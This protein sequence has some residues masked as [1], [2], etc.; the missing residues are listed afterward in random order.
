MLF[1]HI[2]RTIQRASHEPLSAMLIWGSTLCLLGCQSYTQSTATMRKSLARGHA[3]HALTALDQ[4][5]DDDCLD[6]DITSLLLLERGVTRQMVGDYKGAST[7]FQAAD[8]RLEVLDYTNTSVQDI[9]TYLF[10]GDSAPYRPPPFEKILVNLFNLS[11]YLAMGQWGGAKV[12]ARRFAVNESFFIDQG[13]EAI[14]YLST[15]RRQAHLM[16]AF[17][18]K[19]AGDLTLSLKHLEASGYTDLIESLTAQ[20]DEEGPGGSRADRP[21]IDVL[22]ITSSG[23]VPY[24]R[25]VRL[26]IGAALLYIDGYGM[27]A[28]QRRRLSILQA[29]GLVKW[30][31]FPKLVQGKAPREGRLTLDQEPVSPI[32]L[33]PLDDLAE[34]AF[35]TAR[36]KMMIGALTRLLT[37]A[38]T[39]ALTEQVTRKK[40][41]GGLGL[42]LSL[43]TEGAMSATD[44][45]DTRSWTALPAEQTLYWLRLPPGTH[46]FDWR[47]GRRRFRRVITLSADQQA[48]AI[49]FPLFKPRRRE[50]DR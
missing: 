18:F 34:G 19:A 11:N 21:M 40:L 23:F 26:P 38:A 16:A 2:K 43:A 42:L 31:N 50:A 25:A 22:V 47:E 46:R 10:S 28:S 6:S 20:W 39:G 45:P 1:L 41:G 35:E 12:E 3:Q 49:I 32:H 14:S 30:L 9:S 15:L 8:D 24:K 36:P 44:T 5:I 4:Q 48:Q 17:A 13:G 29:K 27:S 37:R 33:T 7:D